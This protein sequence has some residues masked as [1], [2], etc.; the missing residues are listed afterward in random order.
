MPPLKR[1]C[2]GLSPRKPRITDDNSVIRQRRLRQA[3]GLLSGSLE[4]LPRTERGVD[5][6]GGCDV[7]AAIAA[8]RLNPWEACGLWILA[9]YLSEQTPALAHVADI[10]AMDSTTEEVHSSQNDLRTRCAQVEWRWSS[11]HKR[12]H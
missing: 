2:A 7:I 3:T 4:A 5:V 10:Q 12:T 11:M 1:L 9:G 8:C 6:I